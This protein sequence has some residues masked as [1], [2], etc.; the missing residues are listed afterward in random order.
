MHIQK[1]KINDVPTV[2]GTTWAYNPITILPAEVIAY[3]TLLIVK[4]KE[5]K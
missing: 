5:S 2:F 4:R 1:Y 3:R